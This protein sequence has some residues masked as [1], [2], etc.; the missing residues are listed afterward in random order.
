MRTKKEAIQKELPHT[1]TCSNCGKSF[2]EKVLD[3]CRCLMWEI[4]KKKR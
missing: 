1:K 4:G 3:N 2:S